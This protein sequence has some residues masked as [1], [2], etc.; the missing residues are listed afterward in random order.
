MVTAPSRSQEPG[1]SFGSLLRMGGTP[2]LR[3]PFAA[4]Q[5][6]GKELEQLGHTP[7]T[8]GEA[9]VTQAEVLKHLPSQPFSTPSLTCLTLTNMRVDLWVASCQS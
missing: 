2:T 9:D 8:T 1:A 4:F 3:A 7:L 5:A 6:T